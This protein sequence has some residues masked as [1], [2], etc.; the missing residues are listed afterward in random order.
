VPVAGNTCVWQR[1]PYDLGEVSHGWIANLHGAKGFKCPEHF[2]IKEYGESPFLGNKSILVIL[3]VPQNQQTLR[4]KG[5]SCD[6][7]GSTGD[8]D[9][10]LTSVGCVPT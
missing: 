9:I 1:L 7:E 2:D 5:F 4:N 10:V 3:T 8:Q 6:V